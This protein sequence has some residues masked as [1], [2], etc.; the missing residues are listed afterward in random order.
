MWR[1]EV[2]ILAVAAAF[3]V[4]EVPARAQANEPWVGRR[5]IT[6]YGAVLKVGER[7]VDDGRRGLYQ[8][9]GLDKAVFRVY[10]VDRTNGNWLWLV[11]ELGGPSGWVGSDSVIPV[12][13][14]IAR[15]T[16]EIRA[17]PRRA[18]HY[19]NRGLAWLETGENSIAIADFTEAIR[20]DPR[21]DV[22]FQNRGRA[23]YRKEEYDKAIAD[24]TE[25]IRL[26]PGDAL[27][28][29]NRGVARRDKK[30]YAKAIADLTESIRLDPDDAD[31]Y[32]NRAWSWA[33][34]RDYDKA[35]ADFNAAIRLQPGDGFFYANRAWFSATCPSEKYFDGKRALATASRACQLSGWKDANNLGTMAAACAAAGDFDAAVKWQEQAQP[36]YADEKARRE[37]LGRLE[38]YRAGKPYRMTESPE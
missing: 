34:T 3:V 23:W 31:S 29:Q 10:R 37:G 38:L 16:D 28:Y 25:A 12:D 26:D 8:A 5:V 21:N 27:S 35:W 19:V 9:R 22:H 18:V 30:E 17:E 36:L 7:V 14:A 33:A 15:F 13:E 32:L 11:P 24:F 6:K 4:A 2:L 20:L 1:P